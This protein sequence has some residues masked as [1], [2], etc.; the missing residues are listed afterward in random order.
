MFSDLEWL[1]GGVSTLAASQVVAVVYQTYLA[2]LL[3]EIEN[4]GA[5]NLVFFRGFSLF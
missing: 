3:F 2:L 1:K 5:G 4:T